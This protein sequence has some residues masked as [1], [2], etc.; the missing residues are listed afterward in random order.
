MWVSVHFDWRRGPSCEGGYSAR[1]F[2]LWLAPFAGSLRMPSLSSMGTDP[3]TLKRKKFE[4]HLAWSKTCA[5]AP[6]CIES[7]S[8]RRT[9][10]AHW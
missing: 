2:S 3:K 8:I 10:R 4:H 5:R 7:L 6:M 9:Y 1:T